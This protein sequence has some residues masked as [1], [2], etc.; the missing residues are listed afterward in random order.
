ME[1]P[2][3]ENPVRKPVETR[4]TFM[5]RKRSI[6]IPSYRLHKPS[7]Q[8]VVT[9]RGKDRYLGQ[10][11]S[12]P[13]RAEYDRLIAE[14]LANQSTGHSTGTDPADL[15]IAELCSRYV[16]FAEAYYRKHGRLTSEIH[17]IR[18]AVKT[19]RSRYAHTLA[20]DFGPL[21]LKTCRQEWVEEGLT[22]GG[23][24]RLVR[25]VRTIFKWATENE[26]VP[27]ATW[28]TLTAVTG[29]KRGRTL[30][31]EPDP[32][33]PVAEDVL[34]KTLDSA[35]PMIGSMILVQLKTGM[36]PGELV[37]LRGADLDT[38]GP[39][40]IFR[41]LSHKL[42]HQGR[43]RIIFIGPDGQ[44]VLKPWLRDNPT[45]FIFGPRQ[46]REYDLRDQP[47]PRPRTAWER[48]HRKRRVLRDRYT[49]N[50]YL[51]AIRRTCDRAKVNWW[52][53][54]QLRH[55]AATLIRAR[56]GVEAAR[57]V[58]GH[59]N[60]GTTQIYAEA[61]LATAAKIMGEIG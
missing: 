15:T 5:Q 40:W 22:R 13:S 23:I 50:G 47:A 32:V 14:Y 44:V 27:V 39:V 16:G 46:L 3:E 4:G 52:S 2:L 49:S 56:Y 19:L 33:R 58:L 38:S 18:K 6:R 31:P 61:D 26:L 24:N 59:S 37:Q 41:P 34:A 28:Q 12:G 20:S 42:E 51:Q 45:E 7:G 57:T 21:A 10:Y 53:P 30:A 43:E 9:I 1:K 55:A 35:H 29:L 8:A 48:R 36:R 17:S 60:I 54:N 11:G 25:I